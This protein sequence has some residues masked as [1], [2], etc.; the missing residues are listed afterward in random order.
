[1][2]NGCNLLLHAEKGGVDK[3]QELHGKGVLM[4]EGDCFLGRLLVMTRYIES[5]D[6]VQINELVN[7][8]RLDPKRVNE[9]IV[10][11]MKKVNEFDEAMGML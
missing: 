6:A 11:A 8:H 5:N 7:R 9:L 1:M 2:T 10:T 3:S 4:F